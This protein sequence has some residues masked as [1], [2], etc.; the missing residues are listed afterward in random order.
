MNRME[1]STGFAIAML[2]GPSALAAEPGVAAR[3]RKEAVLSNR[4]EEGRPLPLACSWQCGHYRGPTCAGWRPENQMRL[5]EEGHY[6]SPWFHHPDLDDLPADPGDF[7]FEYY[8]KSIE[9]ARA[10]RLPLTFIASQWESGLSRP[11]YLDLPPA[12]NP[13]VVTSDD[14]ILPKVSPFGPVGPWREIGIKQTASARMKKLQEWYPDPPLVTFLSNNE[15]AKLTWK[16]AE[17]DR[18]Y[19]DKHGR[20]RDD[21]F[22]R[23]VIG[24]GWIERYRA[25]Q[26]GMR[27]GLVSPAWKK[28]AV[29]VGYDAFGPPHL[30]RWGGW[31]EYSLHTTGRISPDPLMWDGGSPSYYTHNWNPSTDFTVWSPQVEFQNLVFMQREAYDLAPEFRL[32][33]SIWDGHA[34]SEANDKRKYYADR[35][36]TVTPERYGGFV[37]FGMWLLRPRAVR[38]FRGWTEPWEDN[39]A[40]FLAIVSAVDRVHRNPILREFWRKGELVPNRARKHPH[41]AGIPEEYAA[42]DRWFLLDADVNPAKDSWALSDPIAVF[43]L[44]LVQGASPQRRWLIY[45]HS[46]LGDRRDVKITLPEFGQVTVD[47]SRRGSFYTVDEKTRRITPLE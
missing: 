33:L 17:E 12:E 42:C 9:K 40:H 38:E 11:P 15:H 24:E 8:E 4:S 36:Q 7:F 35:G 43:S 32:E 19:T 30:G 25:L 10:Q 34:P 39:R 6:L 44:A 5:I 2:L 16:E 37:Q 1:W 3:I 28:A 22:R 18:R 47:V 41:Q 14:K 26:E 27:E 31:P 21:E 23:R 13:N 29:F 45:A 20:G 46:P